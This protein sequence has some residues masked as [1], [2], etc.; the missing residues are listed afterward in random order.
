MSTYELSKEAHLNWCAF[1]VQDYNFRGRSIELNYV[2]SNGNKLF[3]INGRLEDTIYDHARSDFNPY[4]NPDLYSLDMRYWFI[5]NR[6]DM[7]SFY[8]KDH[9]TLTVFD[10][11]YSGITLESSNG[12]EIKTTDLSQYNEEGNHW[13]I[14]ITNDTNNLPEVIKTFYYT[15]TDSNGGRTHRA[16]ASVAT[17][18]YDLIN[19]INNLI[20]LFN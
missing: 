2:D 16:D 18:E 12:S 11:N 17:Y 15:L 13:D 3:S 19:Q 8:L 7:F 1:S 9:P 10:N 6:I 5:N 4:G 14:I 20:K